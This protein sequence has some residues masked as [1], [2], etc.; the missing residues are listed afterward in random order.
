MNWAEGTEKWR[1]LSN[2]RQTLAL[3]KKLLHCM[4]FP[5]VHKVW[6]ICNNDF[7]S[8][9]KKKH[10]KKVGKAQA[11]MWS[12]IFLGWGNKEGKGY[13]WFSTTVNFATIGEKLYKIKVYRNVT[14][15]SH[16][17]GRKLRRQLTGVV[18]RE[19]TS[20]IYLDVCA[21]MGTNYILCSVGPKPQQ[22]KNKQK[23]PKSQKSS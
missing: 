17:W 10:C 7:G 11:P 14:S 5:S 15:A 1:L 23:S 22:N 20:T 3:W 21:M 4:L 2:F 16:L 19:T 18:Q 6:Q 9:K 13:F 8:E 12:R